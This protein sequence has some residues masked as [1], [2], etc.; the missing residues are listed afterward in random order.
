MRTVAITIG[1]IAILAVAAAA[2][3]LVADPE[4]IDAGAAAMIAL[5]LMTCGL[6]AL[7]G[8]LLARAPWGRW[9]MAAL[10]VLAMGLATVSDS[11]ATWIALALG[12]GALV[13]LL[14]PWLRLWTRHRPAAEAPGPVPITLMALAPTAPLVVGFTAVEGISW[15]HW[16]VVLVAATGSMLYAQGARS[17][18]WLLRVGVP[19][20]SL[21]AIRETGGWG[22]FALA[23][24]TTTVTMLAWLPAA[25]RTTT[26]IT[27]PL[28]NPVPRKPR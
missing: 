20:A 8:L 18:L 19:I 5:G 11:A 21:L 13:G 22:F 23:V 26:V 2:I 28:P 4:P 9:G 27:P 3:A 16:L 15:A 25:T 14:G 1:A 10:V 24:A 6:T 7:S 12:T 17:G